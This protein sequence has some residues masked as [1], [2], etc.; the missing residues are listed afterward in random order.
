MGE[1]ATATA[2]DAGAAGASTGAAGADA[3]EAKV[4]AG[5]QMPPAEATVKMPAGKSH[6]L[7]GIVFAALGGI[8]WGFSGNCAQ[9]LTAELGVPVL[10]ITA[11]RLTVAAVIFLAIC[12]VRE[13]RHL[14]AAL[15]DGRSLAYIAG[16]A[17]LGVLLTQVS[18]LSA[19]AYT[20]AGT[21][22]VLERTGLVLIMGY[23]CLRTRRLPRPREAAGLVLA[24]G[25]IGRAHV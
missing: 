16:F 19:I 21:G 9:M 5:T 20:N 12:L 10:W 2:A 23:V 6:V 18:Y 4:A 7:R 22:T 3:A 13:P 17:I 1:K 25:E 11:V 24:I 15:R 14:L 8:C